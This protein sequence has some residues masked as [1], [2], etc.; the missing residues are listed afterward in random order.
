M[1]I[2]DLSAP[3]KWFEANA[4]EI[5]RVYAESHSVAKEDLILGM[6]NCVRPRF[7][8]LTVFSVVVG[9]LSAPDYA[10][11]V[12]RNHPDS[13]VCRVIYGP[14]P[15]HMLKLAQTGKF[16]NFYSPPERS[17]MGKIHDVGGIIFV[18]S[19][20]FRLSGGVHS[21]TLLHG[22]G[23]GGVRQPMPVAFVASCSNSV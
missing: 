7:H 13:Q 22:E 3:K 9:T 5:L 4:N 23:F 8:V 2:E 21:P 16:R 11:F 1:Y 17:T 19:R 18:D 20:W 10:L 12:S 6:R 14:S 15:R